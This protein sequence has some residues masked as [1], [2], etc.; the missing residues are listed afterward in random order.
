MD[1]SGHAPMIPARDTRD[2]GTGG[3]D[4]RPPQQRP[5]P[6]TASPADTLPPA[7]VMRL[8]RYRFLGQVALHRGLARQVDA[9]LPVDLGDD[10]HDLVADRHH[11]LYGGHVVVGELADAHE[12]FLAGQD[13]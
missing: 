3:R 11:V 10:D 6:S 8:S 13:L 2:P 1:R 12:P 4:P 7:S 9:A 5:R